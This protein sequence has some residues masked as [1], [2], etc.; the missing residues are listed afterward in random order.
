MLPKVRVLAVMAGP[1]DEV[2][3]L[4]PSCSMQPLQKELCPAKPSPSSARRARKTASPSLTS[5]NQS[6]A[7]MQPVEVQD[8]GVLELLVAR[9]QK[10]FRRL[11]VRLSHRL[12]PPIHTRVSGRRAPGA[13]CRRFATGH[14]P[15]L[16]DALAA[17][18]L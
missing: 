5:V 7:D 9:R 12:P 3:L 10:R 18:V 8:I 17:R 6:L 13:F 16:A 4:K 14:L 11:P 1:R 2:G 15:G